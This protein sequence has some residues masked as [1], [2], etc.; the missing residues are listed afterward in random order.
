VPQVSEIDTHVLAGEL[1]KRND[2]RTPGEWRLHGTNYIVEQDRLTPF[3]AQTGGMRAK[4][5]ADFL[6]FL[7]KNSQVIIERLERLARL[8]KLISE[9]PSSEPSAMP[10][11]KSSRSQSGETA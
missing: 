2:K 7:A 3:L 5:N 9:L 8:E 6:F 11:E 1:R 10:Q 4:A